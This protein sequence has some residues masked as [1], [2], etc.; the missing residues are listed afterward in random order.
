MPIY[1]FKCAACN[2]TRP[3]VIVDEYLATSAVAHLSPPCRCGSTE[4]IR[5]AGAL[6]SDRN[7]AWGKE[8]RNWRRQWDGNGA[9][10]KSNG[11]KV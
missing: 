8:C 7:S 10:Y 5:Q 2:R 6:P 1:T 3:D 11:E 4:F 9:S